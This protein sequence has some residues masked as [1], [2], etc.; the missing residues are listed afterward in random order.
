MKT[1][2]L[3]AIYLVEDENG[4]VTVKSDHIGQGLMCY[5]IGVEILANLTAA[6]IMN[7]EVLSVEYLNYSN[8][9]Q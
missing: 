2:S 9:L 5:E 4:F 8:N 1:R 6:E 7:P 3:F